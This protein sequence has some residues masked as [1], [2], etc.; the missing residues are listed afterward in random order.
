MQLRTILP[1]FFWAL[2]LSVSAGLLGGIVIC[3]AMD[4]ASFADMV[5]AIADK[6]DWRTFFEQEIF[7]ESRFDLLRLLLVVMALLWGGSAFWLIRHQRQIVT[8]VGWWCLMAWRKGRRQLSFANKSELY[9]FFFILGLFLLRSLWNSY[10]YALQYD[11]A[12]TYNHFVSK[13][14]LVSLISPNNN[15]ILYTLFASL[16]DGWGLPVKYALR[17]PVLVGGLAVVTLFYL[18]VRQI[19][20]WRWALLGM[21][22]FAFSPA[23]MFYT[24]YARGY[25]FQLF[26][27]VLG[28]WAVLALLESKPK[29]AFFWPLW[30]VTLVL[31]TYSVPTHL[32][33]WLGFNVLLLIGV[34][35]KKLRWQSW[36]ATN[37]GSLLVLM[38]LFFPLFM[39]SG[40]TTLWNAATGVTVH[41]ES[42]WNYQN[43]VAD[44]LLVGGGRGTPV[45]WAMGLLVLSIGFISRKA[46]KT[47]RWLAYLCLIMVALPTVVGATLGT[48][49]PYRAWCFITPFIVIGI[50]LIISGWRP[51]IAKQYVLVC[52]L[53]LG[54]LTF[55]R[56][57]VHYFVHWSEALDKEAHQIANKM[58]QAAI[59]SCYFFSNY[60]KPL[61]IC[62]YL[63]QEKVLETPMIFEGSK[64]YAPFVKGKIYEAVLW[65]KEDRQAQA[66]EWD[67][68]Q[69]HYPQLLYENERIAIYIP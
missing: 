8:S 66:G 67:W 45:Y 36:L 19:M 49:T 38:V 29:G 35:G 16:L 14:L 37:V 56:S 63:E 43:R 11:E 1:Y 48:Q 15:H 53:V 13:G 57:E 46:T 22:L 61:L 18:F 24:L 17:L 23:V 39:T 5:L 27:T 40:M 7:P 25:I 60:D 30:G 68:L 3:Y 51:K 44:W 64:D 4:Y 59:S 9:L 21:L 41:G 20:D 50:L 32:Y 26:F 52:G 47:L 42:F 58:M 10:H 69:Q 65:D 33:V 31:G 54:S 62:Y 34:L 55:W 28:L 6:E 2:I 12:W